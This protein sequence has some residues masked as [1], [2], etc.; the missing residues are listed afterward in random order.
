MSSPAAVPVAGV[1][2][3]TESGFSAKLGGGIPSEQIPEL[4]IGNG[5]GWTSPLSSWWFLEGEGH[6][7]AERHPYGWEARGV[8]FLKAPASVPASH[9]KVLSDGAAF[10]ALKNSRIW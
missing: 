4:S 2:T 9:F 8:C 10:C 3:S 6:A 7:W 1:S 5:T